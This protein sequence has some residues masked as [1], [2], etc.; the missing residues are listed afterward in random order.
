[1]KVLSVLKNVPEDLQQWLDEKYP[2]LEFRYCHGMKEGEPFLEEA[3][4]LVTYGEDLDKEKIE[5]AVNLKW[6]MVM[7]AGMDRMPFEAI[8]ERGVLVTNVRG[9]HAQ[10]MAEYAIGM[11]LQNA[12]RMKELHLQEKE[13]RWNRRLEFQEMNGHTMTLLGTGAIASE[14]ARLA[15]CFNMKTVGVSRSGEAKKH[16]DEVFRIDQL[17]EALETGDY[18]TAVLPSTEETRGLL[19]KEHF[20]AMPAHAVFLN[21][22]R[23]ELVSTDVLLEAVQEGLISHAILDVM[24]E[25]PLP[26]EHALWREE[27]ITVTPHISGITSRYLPRGFEIFD[28]NIKAYIENETMENVIDLERGY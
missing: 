25:E 8:R 15:K 23:G 18:V 7:S 3:D 2:S 6:I 13:S 16:F 17:T 28:R 11:F 12:K 10:P 21:M 22:G 19:R 26:A 14:T 20:E 1:M 27:N 5:K 4:I 9:I 24:E